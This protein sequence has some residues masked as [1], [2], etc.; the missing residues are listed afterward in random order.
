MRGHE[1]KLDFRDK[2]VIDEE[3]GKMYNI[4]FMDHFAEHKYIFRI[5]NG[6]H[7]TDLSYYDTKKWIRDLQ[8]AHHYINSQY[9]KARYLNQLYI[10]G[11]NEET[12]MY[13]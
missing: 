1:R 9:R 8:M 4:R 13:R 7:R 6:E 3:R 10:N 12:L 5:I 2:I 11:A